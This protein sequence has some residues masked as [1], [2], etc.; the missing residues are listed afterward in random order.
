MNTREMSEKM[1]IFVGTLLI[2]MGSKVMEFDGSVNKF[3]FSKRSLDK[4]RRQV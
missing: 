1:W 2:A 4:V 3:K